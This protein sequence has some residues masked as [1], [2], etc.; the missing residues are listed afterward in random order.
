MK[1][2]GTCTLFCALSW[3]QDLSLSFVQTL[4]NLL[5]FTYLLR[6]LLIQECCSQNYSENLVRAFRMPSTSPFCVSVCDTNYAYTNISRISRCAPHFMVNFSKSPLCLP[7]PCSLTMLA[8]N[9]FK[10][11]GSFSP[12]GISKGFNQQSQSTFSYSGKDLSM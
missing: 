3:I 4:I 1:R 7:L 10:I 9:C 8:M 6:R 5:S 11:S 2:A 12:K